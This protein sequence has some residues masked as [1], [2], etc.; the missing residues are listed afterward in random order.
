MPKKYET[1]SFLKGVVI[2]MNDREEFIIVRR[3]LRLSNLLI[4]MHQEELDV[5]ELTYM[6]AEVLVYFHKFE[7]NR[8]KDLKE[9]LNISHQAARGLVERLVKKGFLTLHTSEYDAREK[10]VF[11]S[12]AGKEFCVNFKNKEIGDGDR[13][14]HN[15]DQKMRGEFLQTISQMIENLCE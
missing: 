2:R 13:V 8:A 11:L 3:I 6:Q 1:A 4:N 10:L 5:Y 7:G 9:Y 12:D 14:F 15:I